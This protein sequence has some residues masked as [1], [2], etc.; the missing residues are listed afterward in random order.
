M[1]RKDNEDEERRRGVNAMGREAAPAA[2]IRDR[3]DAS[4]VVNVICEE[5]VPEGVKKCWS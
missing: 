2:R 5:M 4:M 1:W 3:V